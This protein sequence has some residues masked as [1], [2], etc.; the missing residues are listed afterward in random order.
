MRQL[1]DNVVQASKRREEKRHE[2]ERDE[3]ERQ[4]KEMLMKTS[5]ADAD[6]DD[7]NYQSDAGTTQHTVR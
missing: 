3:E 5:D 6:A 1:L 7:D 2:E 4:A